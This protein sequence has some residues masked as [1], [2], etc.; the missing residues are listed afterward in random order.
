MTKIYDIFKTKDPGKRGSGPDTTS[1]R[2]RYHEYH[3]RSRR[4]FVTEMERRRLLDYQREKGKKK[5]R[6]ETKRERRKKGE[7]EKGEMREEKKKGNLLKEEGKRKRE[8]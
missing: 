3:L 1:T 7:I 8:K 2:P 4:L 6:S 5:K